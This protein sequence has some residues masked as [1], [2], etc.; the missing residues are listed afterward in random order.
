VWV[1]GTSLSA[2]HAGSSLIVVSSEFGAVG[3]G[4]LR[5]VVEIP[6]LYAF[7]FRRLLVEKNGTLAGDLYFVSRVA[8]V[9][10]FSRCI[11]QARANG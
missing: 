2:C 7:R 3:I 5:Q 8:D 11:A 6:T 10:C 9:F 4:Y 1:G